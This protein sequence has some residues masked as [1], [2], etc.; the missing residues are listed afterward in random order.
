M[1]PRRA[2]GEGLRGRDG[3]QRE[4]E[5]RRV[6]E[7]CRRRRR[8]G[9]DRLLGLHD[10][11]QRRFQDFE[12][13]VGLDDL[14]PVA[15]DPPPAR[16]QLLQQP[17]TRSADR[18]HAPRLRRR[19][20]PA[21]RRRQQKLP[22]GDVVRD[23]LRPRM[24]RQARHG[25]LQPQL[26]DRR[27]A[28]RHGAV[29]HARLQLPRQLLLQGQFA[30]TDSQLHRDAHGDAARSVHG[31]PQFR[32]HVQAPP[33]RRDG[34]LR[35]H[36]RALPLPDGQFDLCAVGQGARA[37]IGRQLHGQQQGYEGGADL[38]F[39]PRELQ[40]R[41]ALHPLVHGPCRRFV[42]IR[43]G[44][45][46]GLLSRRRRRMERLG[47][48]VLERAADQRPETARELRH[49]GQQRHRVVRRLRFVQHGAELRRPLDDD[50]L[51]D[52]QQCAALGDYYAVRHR[53]RSGDVPEPPAHRGRLLQQGD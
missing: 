13:A 35:L 17:R 10:A 18:A 36:G 11:R 15:F 53:V 52:G 26:G 40:L 27:R 50:R 31:L 21:A 1:V 34:R 48:E 51:G 41:Q 6:G 2:V 47:R 25:Q 16:R 5:I 32:P 3:R 24:R 37:P 20:Q 33:D 46:V 30:R 22:H 44:Q 4:R 38:L 29:R 45:Q 39:R 19:R 28:D 14:R 42:E 23:L 12:A 8:G 9:D 7:L 43:A 49:D